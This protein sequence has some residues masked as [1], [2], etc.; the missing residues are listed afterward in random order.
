MIKPRPIVLLSVAGLFVWLFA[1]ALFRGEVFVF[2][3][4]GHYYYPLFQLVRGEW[5]AGRV[6]LWNPYENLG[7][8]LAGNPTSSVFY[9]GTLVFLLPL[10]Y[11][12]AYKLY[13]MGHLLLAAW[14]AYRLAR[15]WGGSVEASGMG[16]MSYAFSGNVLFQYC[17][18]IFLVGAAWLP[19]AVLAADRMLRE[20]SGFRG[21]GSAFR[22]RGPGSREQGNGRTDRNPLGGVLA[23]VRAA[24]GLGAVLAL[25]TLGGNAEMAYHAG[26]IAAFYAAWLWSTERIATG[27]LSLWERVR[28]RILTR[29]V[30]SPVSVASPVPPHPDPLPEGEGACTDNRPR[31]LRLAASRPA[32]LALAAAVALLLSA[33][34]VLP[35]ME[36]SRRSGR[37]AS[38][39]ARSV[40]ELPRH[41]LRDTP[42]SSADQTHWADGLLCRR[43]EP[44]THH[45]H[46]YHFSVGPWRLAEYLWPNASG[47]QF[48]V[49]HRWI[50]V[51]RGEEGRVWVP[52]LYMGLFPI[53]L[54]LAALRLR[55]AQ[56]QQTWLSWLAILSVVASFG[57]YG[58]GWL[59]HAIQ[60]AAGRDPAGPWLVGSPFGGLYWLLTVLLPGYISFRYP[61]K[62]LVIAA[63]ALSMLAV[64][65]WDR[66]WAKPSPR[67]RRGLLCLGGLSLVGTLGVL[68]MCP[69][70]ERWLGHVP[71]NVLF[72]PLDKTGACLDLLFAFLQTA[73]LCG[74]GWWL[75]RCTQRGARWTQAAAL[76]LVA[77]DLAVANGWMV[78]CAPA[79]QWQK[80]PELAAVIHGEQARRGD[81]QP[82]RVFRHPV[83]LPP[84][85]ST[86]GSPDRVTEGMRWDRDTLFA[87]HNL[88]EGIPLAEVQ[89]TMKPFDYQVFLWVGRTGTSSRASAGV[90][91]Q[92]EPGNEVE[93]MSAPVFPNLLAKYLILRGGDR[94]PAMEPIALGGTGAEDL[95]DV[96]LWHNPGHLPRAWIVD[97]VDVLPPLSSDDPREVW[98]RT[99]DV[100]YADGRPRNLRE[101]AVVEADGWSPSP[102]RE[103]ATASGEPTCRIVRYEPSCVEIEARLDRPGLVVLADQFYPGWRLE[104]ETAG[105]G[106]REV[107]ILR[108]NRVMR[109]AWLPAGRHRLCYRYHPTSVL[110]GACLSALAWLALA[111]IGLATALAGRTRGPTAWAPSRGKLGETQGT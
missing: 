57:G 60:I 43:L 61:A 38:T 18:V 86:S 37:A 67:M 10:D 44:G 66:A 33:V 76:V 62:L 27:P 47:R 48:P 50:E 84:S 31:L 3:D 46:A 96:S 90:R 94:M 39:T 36:L 95:L 69:F 56:A 64:R 85:W 21:Q 51:I 83:W 87:K 77:V 79:P 92:A 42:R 41:L 102:G 103:A 17:N 98:R 80:R 16:A 109:A 23:K 93:G 73:V 14:A 99:T 110:G 1:D 65:G 68:A 59:V 108:T 58:L 4:A 2:R 32:L 7:V 100:L 81:D 34:Q 97:R 74:A 22:G 25:M 26:L 30:A 72:G 70:R 9:P 107:P 104:V 28:V 105:R 82:Y 35:S 24:L 54:A 52:S 11:A 89:G 91:S 45:Q 8:P 53:L 78:A 75:L 88:G 71:S 106:T 29:V 5:A 12:W 15:R 55:K 6:P 19:L 13:V 63:L 20:G 49:H 111:A 40:Y 101:S